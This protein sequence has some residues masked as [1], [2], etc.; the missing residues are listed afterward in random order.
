[1]QKH[2]ADSVSRQAQRKSNQRRRQVERERRRR[3]RQS[4]P[5]V[6]AGR[7]AREPK[8]QP[9]AR[10]YLVRKFWEHLRLGELLHKAGVKQKFKGLPA[11]TL[12]IV[13]LTFGVFNAHSV[14]D[15]AAKAQADPVLLEACWAQGL[16]RKQLYRFLGQVT[17]TMYLAWLGDIVRELQRDPRTATHRHGVVIGDDTTVFK[18]GKKMPY[19]TLVYKSSGRRFGL[20]NIIVSVHYADWHKDFPVCFDFWRPTPQQIQAA[21]DKRDRKRLKVD[22]RKPADV[23]RWIEHQVQHGQAPDLAILH[24]AQFGPVVVGKCDELGLA[25]I[26]VGGG[27]RQYVGVRPDGSRISSVTAQ[28]L[29]THRYRANEWLELTDVGYR[30]VIVGQADVESVGCISLLVAEDLADQERTLFITRVDSD[31]VIL[32]RLELAVAQHADADTSRLQVML[33]LLKLARQAEVQAETAVF[34][35]W[36]YVTDFIAQVLVLG[37]ARVVTKVKRDIPYTYQGQTYTLDQLW[38]LISAKRFRRQRVRGQWVKLAS[39]PVRQEGLGHIK[40]VWVKELGAHNK[41][42]QQ[43]VLMCTDVTF[44]N[45]HVYRA[46]KLRW[47]IEECYREVKQHHGLE[48]YHARD[49]NANF[50]HVALSFLS[51]LC[52]VVTRLL[53]PKLRDKTLGQVKQLVFDALVE[54]EQGDHGFIVKFSSRFRREVGLPAYCT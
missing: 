24:G 5:P 25:W 7:I 33:R 3:A 34:D 47:K 10:S 26:A 22:Q 49:F 48:L 18:S 8:T 43:Y 15:L 13:A 6:K 32:Q 51:Y 31:E 17:D 2:K 11:V 23:A 28:G 37:F 45:D 35:R 27:K 30:V 52:L 39:L 14:S 1:M 53:T 38:R 42:L 40:L 21:Q 12:M 50:G 16:E 9:Q 44:H 29:L 54:L 46:Y 36:F 4:W 41:I 19:V 20:G